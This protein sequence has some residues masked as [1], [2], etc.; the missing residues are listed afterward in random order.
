M[1]AIEILLLK[2]LINIAVC[3]Q[4]TKD[5]SKKAEKTR[6]REGGGK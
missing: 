4:G 3:T 5:S 2:L 1:F 6:E